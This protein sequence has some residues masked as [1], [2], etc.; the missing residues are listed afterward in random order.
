MNSKLFTTQPLLYWDFGQQN[1]V[2][3]ELIGRSRE[4][5]VWRVDSKGDDGR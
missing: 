4:T 3:H 2:V 1:Q 5:H